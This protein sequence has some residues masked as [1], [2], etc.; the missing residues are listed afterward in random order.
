LE[1]SADPLPIAQ[2][3]AASSGGMMTV[4]RSLPIVVGVSAETGSSVALRWAVDEAKRR[5]ARVVAILA[6]EPPQAQIPSGSIAPGVRPPDY[7]AISAAAQHTLETHVM[8]TVG[9][10]HDVTCRAEQ[11]APDVVLGA[12]SFDA[13]LLVLDSPRP[14]R[15]D[16][17]RKGLLAPKLIY[18]AGCPV[19]V[20]PP[21]EPARTTAQK[22]KDAA[23]SLA[24][25]AADA[26]AKATRPVLRH[27][28][29]GT[30]P[31]SQE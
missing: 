20:I 24:S 31:E 12:E 26:A 14:G 21:D 6:W 17:P 27:P 28:S 7:S 16:K 5:G 18:T 13:Q 11:G 19:V 30:P 22:M 1:D 25:A 8:V 4:T 10:V 15:A 29:H 3:S 9:S 2:T 23:R